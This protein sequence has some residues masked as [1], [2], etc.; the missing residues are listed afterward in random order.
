MVKFDKEELLKLAEISA[1]KLYDNETDDLVNQIKKLLNYTEELK[2]VQLSTEIAPIKN[3]NIFRE[4]E[5][6]NFD[7]SKILKQA[8]K[9]KNG[10][11]V[12]PQILKK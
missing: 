9:Q 1:L 12:V 7:S 10:F 11:F 4:D 2:K 8:P 6:I 3:I 5:V